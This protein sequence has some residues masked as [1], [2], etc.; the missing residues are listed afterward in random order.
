MNN[1]L[2]LLFNNLNNLTRLYTRTT[3]TT[4]IIIKSFEHTEKRLFTYSTLSSHNLSMV[5]Q[6]TNSNISTASHSL[7]ID[8][9][10]SLKSFSSLKSLSTH[11]S[12]SK[13]IKVFPIKAL[14]D[15][16]MYLL[17]DDSTRQ[18]AAVDPVNASAMA[19]AVS[20][21]GVELKAILTTHHHHDH[22]HGNADMLTMFPQITV[23]G[24]DNRIQAL[25]KAVNHGDVIRLGSLNIECLSTPC[26]TKGHICYYVTTID[27]DSVTTNADSNSPT[28]AGNSGP[29]SVER[30]V[31]TGD[32]LFIAG[33][34]RFFEGSP[35]QMDQNLNITLA[36]LPADTKVYCGH[37]YTVANLKFALTVEPQNLDIKLKLTWAQNKVT[38]KE[39]TVPSTIGEEKRINPFMRLKRTQVKKFTGE[40]DELEVMTVLRQRKND[41]NPR[42]N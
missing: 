2:H 25:T 3:L 30:V 28:T 18:A 22:A 36:N 4:A 24:G 10:K 16:Y 32:T 38:K 27:T 7:P 34:G 42:A 13:M 26:H 35:E 23:Y 40:T 1:S 8:A 19:S 6:K 14:Q 17:V 5:K 11:S 21:Y 33:C 29:A 39:P 9:Y 12:I 31:F 41:F 37:E 15:N 20:D